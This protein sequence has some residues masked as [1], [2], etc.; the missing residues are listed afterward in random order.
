MRWKMNSKI[1]LDT[2]CQIT[3][4]TIPADLIPDSTR[5]KE[6]WS[7]HPDE[8][9]EIVIHGKHVKV[10]RWNRAYE[11][12]Y[13]FSNQI[14]IA[15]DVPESLKSY[16]EWVQQEI[17]PRINGLF[18]NWHD[19]SLS[20]YHGKHRDSTKG[21]I[22]QTPI[23]TISLGEERVFRMRPYPKGNLIKDFVLRNGDFIIIP[24]RTNQ[25]W[26]HEIPKFAKYKNH[27]ISVTM[28]AF[29]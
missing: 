21:L 9:S 27:R 8:Y 14:A 4:G 17:D 6:L 20:H 5:F 19:G 25:H 3:T 1:D 23:I 22:P 7:L 12:D 24:W 29:E 13:P 2:D 11:K 18:V 15:H 28:R 10:P 26:T 16:L